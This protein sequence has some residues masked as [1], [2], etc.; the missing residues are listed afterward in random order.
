MK[1]LIL[2][3]IHGSSYYAKKIEEI[4][5]KERPDKIICL[6]DLYY[7]RPRNELTLEYSPMEVA[8][9]LNSLKERL[10][11]LRGNCDAQV[12]EAI[13]EFKF[14]ENIQMKINGY[15]VF[16]THGHK[17]NMDNM[18]P[19]GIDIDIMI[20]GHFHIGFIEEE[21]GVI[22]ANPGSISL[23]R[24]KSEHSYLIMEQNELILKNVDGKVLKR[25]ELQ[26]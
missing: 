17:Y 4:Y 14:E 6:G 19:V 25:Y 11:V 5:A 1:V 3:D 10:I 13:S 18:P 20:Y 8:K 24:E 9:V 21:N 16:L 23:P 15:N 7:H 12:D 2:S 22:F 26:K